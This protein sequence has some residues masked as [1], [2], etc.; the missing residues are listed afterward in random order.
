MWPYLVMY[1]LPSLAALHDFR[2]KNGGA[3]SLR[4]ER[5]N[6]H[7]AAIWFTLTIVIGYRD[8]VGA[9]WYNYLR[10][11]EEVRGSDFYELVFTSDPAYQL[12][13]W[14]SD[15]MDWG[16]F[17]VNLVGG[18]IFAFGLIA[19]C[20][21]QPLPWLA[22]AIAVPYLVIV[23]AMGYTRQGIALGLEMLGLMRLQRGSVG[24]FVACLGLAATFHKSA[25]LVIPIAALADSRNRYWTAAW[26]AATCAVLFYLLLASDAESLIATYVDN[27]VSS[28]GA[29][30][31]LLM[32]AVPAAILL[33]WR[34]RFSF[35]SSEAALWRSVAIISLLLLAL[36]IVK[37]SASTALD[38]MAVYVMPLQVVVFSRLPLA[39]GAKS[40][41]RSIENQQPWTIPTSSGTDN[42]MPLLAAVLLYYGLVQ[43][44]W[45]NFANHAYAW[46]P[47][48]LYLMDY[49]I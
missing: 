1:A 45:L 47:Y 3:G 46:V 44:V 32:N 31:R 4:S 38:R 6:L 21:A 48:R 30:Q 8:R 9:D 2:A 15:E 18:A 13:N 14:I 10:H 41:N 39:F 35:P 43:I 37:P 22:L 26:V 11:F 34:S 19:F 24:G 5:V 23:V 17:G 16:I 36:F 12:L 27:E 49:S 28:E 42:G 25:V 40:Q 29:L 7:W 33:T 20:S